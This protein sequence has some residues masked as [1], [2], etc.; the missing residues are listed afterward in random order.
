MRRRKG[1]IVTFVLGLQ[2]GDGD[3][4]ILGFCAWTIMGMNLEVLAPMFLLYIYYSLP[5]RL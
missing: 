4:T 2:K 3:G 1:Y 5:L